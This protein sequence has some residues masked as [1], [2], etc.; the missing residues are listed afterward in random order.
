MGKLKPIRDQGLF[1]NLEEDLF[2]DQDELK[3]KYPAMYEILGGDFSGI[4]A[5]IDEAVKE[6]DKKYGKKPK[7]RLRE[8]PKRKPN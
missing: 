2:M 7:A 4:T 1:V 5:A 8:I 3:K 6:A